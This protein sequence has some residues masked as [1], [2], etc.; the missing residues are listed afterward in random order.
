MKKQIQFG[1]VC[2]RGT[3]VAHLWNPVEKKW[4]KIPESDF[5]TLLNV[6]CLVRNSPDPLQII[7]EIAK[8]IA[9]T[10]NENNNN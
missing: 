10:K 2:N 9:N 8:S 7:Q 5:E 6:Q 4:S 1:L 3:K